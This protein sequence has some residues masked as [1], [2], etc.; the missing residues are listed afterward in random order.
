MVDMK[1]IA[2]RLLYAGPDRSHRLYLEYLRQGLIPCEMKLW[3][4]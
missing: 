1:R 3:L 4:K 2:E